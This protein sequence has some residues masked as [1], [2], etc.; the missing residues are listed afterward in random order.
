MCTR[1]QETTG[2]INSGLF[3]EDFNTERSKQSARGRPTAKLD[4]NT[5]RTDERVKCS[6]RNPGEENQREAEAGWGKYWERGGANEANEGQVR[7]V[8][9]WGGERPHPHK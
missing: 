3:I 6:W 9:V 1:L 8:K 5:N 2:P 4:S 7:A